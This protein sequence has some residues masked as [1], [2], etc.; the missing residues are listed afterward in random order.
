MHTDRFDFEPDGSVIGMG[1]DIHPR[2]DPAGFRSAWSL[3]DDP[4]LLYV[5]RID[6][7]KGALEAFRFFEAYKDRNPGPLKFVLAGAAVFELPNHPDVIHVGFL[8]EGELHVQLG[9][10][11]LAVGAQVLVAEAAGDLDIATQPRHLEELFEE[12]G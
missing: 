11:G 2:A 6:T 5:G 8:D 9:E 3:G 10:L 12:L 1:M 7:A 4:Y